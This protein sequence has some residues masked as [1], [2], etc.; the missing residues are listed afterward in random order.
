[1]VGQLRTSSAQT[2]INKAS[3]ELY[4][5][6][7]SETGHDP[8]WLQCGGLQIASCQERL[9]QLQRSVAMA[10]VNGVAAEMLSARECADFWPIM[11]TD[12]LVGGVHLPSDG[13][14][15]PGECA[16]AMAIGAIQGGV[17]IFGSSDELV[18]EFQ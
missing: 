8:G 12:D 1:M 2:K 6:L 9:F 14:V 3:T 15:L 10:N 4:A 11:R 17:K 13:R 5:R 16:K 18:G 7:M